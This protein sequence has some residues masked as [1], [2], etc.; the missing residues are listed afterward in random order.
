MSL[1]RYNKDAPPGIVTIWCAK[2][3]TEPDRYYKFSSSVSDLNWSRTRPN[4]LAIGFYDGTVRVIDISK[5]QLTII[6]Q[7]DR[8]SVPSYEPHWQVHALHF[9]NTLIYT[10]SS[11][12]YE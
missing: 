5:K 2:S 1:Q 6:R 11:Y 4:L 12:Q 9:F 7:S 10:T 8:K 3:P